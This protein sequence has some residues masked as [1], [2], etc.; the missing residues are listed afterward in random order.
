MDEIKSF[1]LQLEA[2]QNSYA[3]PQAQLAYRGGHRLNGGYRGIGNNGIRGSF[4]IRDGR[5]NYKNNR[6]NSGRRMI[7][8]WQLGN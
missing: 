8:K 5:E 3:P 6:G 2:D 1:I 4:D 7:P